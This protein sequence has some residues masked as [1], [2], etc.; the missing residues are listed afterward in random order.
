MKHLKIKQQNNKKDK[1][2][3]GAYIACKDND[4]RTNSK[5]KDQ[6]YP[7]FIV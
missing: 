5:N 4:V 6:E 7:F 3:K 1:K 2:S